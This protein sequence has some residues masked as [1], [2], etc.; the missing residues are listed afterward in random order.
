MKNTLKVTDSKGNE[1][2][3]TTDSAYKF[4]VVG[5]VFTPNRNNPD[6]R[7]FDGVR[8]VFGWTTDMKGVSRIMSEIDRSKGTINRRDTVYGH[9]YG[10]IDIEILTVA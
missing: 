8:A 6:V 7:R 5:T 4:A 10:G 9:C 1:F 3:R 2:T